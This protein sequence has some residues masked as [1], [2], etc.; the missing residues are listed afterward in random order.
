MPKTVTIK[1][2]KPLA[3]HGAPITNVVLREPTFAEY[4]QYGDP[5]IYVPLQ[6]GGFFPS[7]NLDVISKYMTLC[8]VEPK[9]QLILEQGGMDLA[10]RIKDAV[11]GFFLPDVAAV[12]DSPKKPTS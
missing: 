5:L 6:S 9:D 8:V 4:V 3:G 1:L 7:E 2:E 10:R 11:I 12:E